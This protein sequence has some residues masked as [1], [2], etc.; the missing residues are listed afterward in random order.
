MSDIPDFSLSYVPVRQNS[1]ALQSTMPKAPEPTQ[2]KDDGIQNGMMDLIKSG[3]LKGSNGQSGYQSMMGAIGGADTGQGLMS[4][5]GNLWKG[6]NGMYGPGFSSGGNV[7]G[8]DLMK[9]YGGH[10]AHALIAHHW[11]TENTDKWLSRG[12]NHDE[13]P[14]ETQHF[15]DNALMGGDDKGFSSG[16]GIKGYAA[17]G[18]SPPALSFGDSD[19]S[20]MGISGYSNNQP[21]TSNINKM[22]GLQN[23]TP[24]P[25]QNMS[26]APSGMDALLA[27]Q[28][29]SGGIAGTTIPDAPQ[30]GMDTVPQSQVG[31]ASDTPPA[32]SDLKSQLDKN[33]PVLD[34]W[35][36]IALAGAGMMA[37]KNRHTLGQIGEGVQEGLKT[38]AGQKQAVAEYALKQAEAEK[39]AEQLAIEANRYNKMLQI[40]QEKVDQGKFSLVP[41]MGKDEKGNDVAGSYKLNAKTGEQTFLPGVVQSQKAN[42][43][44]VSGINRPPEL[45]NLTGDD[46]IAGLSKSVNPNYANEIKSLADTGN[47][48]SPKTGRYDNS[49]MLEDIYRYKG[50]AS[51]ASKTAITRFDSGVNANQIRFNSTAMTHLDTLVQAAQALKNND[52]QALNKMQNTFK[53][54]FGRSAP[55]NFNAARD[56]AAGEIVKAIT[57]TGGTLEDRKNAEQNISNAESPEQLAGVINTYQTMLG[58][59]LY[60]QFLEYKSSTGQSDDKFLGK[61]DTSAKNQ[62]L[63]IMAQHR[64]SAPSGL[65]MTDP[66]IQ[67]AIKAGYTED[68]IKQHLG[69]K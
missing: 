62:M 19:N 23:F 11:G 30:G 4:T 5:L 12:S 66:K 37:S 51:S 32:L 52:T 9:R 7:S 50:D 16:G 67:A 21:L 18:F 6:S 55:T 3:A 39:R 54:Q 27:A 69:I 15:V 46:F 33:A 65:D 58:G 24:M 1:S 40:E 29:P 28:Q 42:V 13:V 36:A 63:D 53:T 60:N 35:Q 2:Q 45:S 68:Q 56:L 10:K 44:A 48:P 20:G 25:P 41:G 34:K 43:P 31:V 17:G 64:G 22:A 47:I 14:M 26:I 59:Q 38:Y 49:Q 61:L 57:Q 8:S